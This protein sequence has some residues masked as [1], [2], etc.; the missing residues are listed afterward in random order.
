MNLLL[1]DELAALEVSCY[2]HGVFEQLAAVVATRLIAAGF[3]FVQAGRSSRATTDLASEDGSIVIEIKEH[4]PGVRELYAAITQLALAADR[5]E[6]RRAVLVLWNSRFSEGSTQREWERVT[7]LFDRK[8]RT[9]MQLAAIWAE[10]QILLPEDALT[11]E[12]ARALRAAATN[13]SGP[14]RK[15]EKRHEIFKLLLLRWIRNEGPIAVKDLQALVGASFPTVSK[16]VGELEK[17]LIRGPDRSVALQSFPAEPW[18]VLT[19]LSPRL[20]QTT[21]WMDRS[22][23]P[24]DLERL[25]TR[26]ARIRE[27]ELALGGV[28]AA[29]HWDPEFDLDGVPRLDICVH[30]PRGVLDLGFLA[31]VDPG[32]GPSR[33]P[34]Q[35]ILV[36]HVLTRSSAQFTPAGPKA[37]SWADPVET[38]LDLFELR[39]TKQADEMVR[40]LRGKP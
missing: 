36:V 16:A 12:I 4:L 18:R 34:A 13:G 31:K 27:P 19:A 15:I 23:R 6:V 3:K 11:L 37:L 33:D 29:R 38:L 17:H 25:A 7:G 30:A 22:G 21:E 9:K 5:S 2:F 32:L 8:V 1:D 40:H 10:R 28:L 14:R 26:L 24:A 20:R 39:L 35:T